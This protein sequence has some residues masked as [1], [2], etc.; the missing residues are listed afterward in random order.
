MQYI[1]SHK[2]GLDTPVFFMGQDTR[3]AYALMLYLRATY[4]TVG[5]PYKTILSAPALIS[6]LS[7]PAVATATR[8]PIVPIRFKDAA[9]SMTLDK[10]VQ[11]PITDENFIAPCDIHTLTEDETAFG[12]STMRSAVK[13]YSD[14]KG[15]FCETNNLM[16]EADQMVPA[17]I[18]YPNALMPI[19]VGTLGS[20]F[21]ST[22][23][24]TQGYFQDY[25]LEGQ[26]PLAVVGRQ[27]HTTVNS[28]A[29]YGDVGLRYKASLASTIY[30]NGAHP[31]A[32]KYQD[33]KN[34]I[35][36][37]AGNNTL[38][39]ILVYH[40]SKTAS[41]SRA[42]T[43]VCAVQYD[44]KTFKRYDISDNI[45]AKPVAY[46]HGTYYTVKVDLPNYRVQL[47]I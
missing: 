6:N 12:I 44:G 7:T 11:T 14:G 38:F 13:V 2:E 5:A 43:P 36:G 18:K 30:Q 31:P 25:S 28:S 19:V 4:I 29:V 21:Y 3:S 15:I 10:M 42:T 27:A 47:E 9:S 20:T 39:S 22:R 45:Y 32:G 17:P 46:E 40:D 37:Y 1:T 41:Y 33:R 16:Y 35:N 23:D 24:S 26:S 8:F 34:D